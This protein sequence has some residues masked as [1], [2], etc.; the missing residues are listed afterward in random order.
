MLT[1][2]TV[3]GAGN[4]FLLGVAIGDFGRSM[5]AMIAGA[6]IAL[7]LVPLYDGPGLFL[8][9]PAMVCAMMVTLAL[10]WTWS[11]MWN[12]V[13]TGIVSLFL[14]CIAGGFALGMLLIV[15]ALFAALDY[16]HESVM[17]ALLGLG[18]GIGNAVFIGRVFRAAYRV[19]GS[20]SA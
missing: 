2:F 6:F 3:F 7:V 13:W 19:Q 1:A 8:A 11:G 18:L 10:E 16:K 5:L 14:A 12:A 15:G 9:P 20:G 17:L 4:G